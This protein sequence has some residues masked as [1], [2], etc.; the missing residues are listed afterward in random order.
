MKNYEAIDWAID[1]LQE[2]L[3]QLCGGWEYEQTLNA[4]R[5]LQEM[6]KSL[7]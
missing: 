2:K 5:T 6:K 1:A 7:L 3:D 4:I